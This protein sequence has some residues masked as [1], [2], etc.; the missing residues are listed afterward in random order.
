ML[1][2]LGVGKELRRSAC[3]KL[4]W[5]MEQLQ[6]LINKST[7]ESDFKALIGCFT[8]EK[9]DNMQPE[10]CLR[11]EQYILLAQVVVPEFP[12]LL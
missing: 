5:K 1:R 11:T 9:R 4:L 12:S 8:E 6:V 2:V 7:F 3:K 10:V